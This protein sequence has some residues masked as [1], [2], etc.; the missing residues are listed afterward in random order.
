MEAYKKYMPHS[1]KKDEACTKKII[2][3]LPNDHSS[4]TGSQYTP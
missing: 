2:Y 1:L 4:T 3:M